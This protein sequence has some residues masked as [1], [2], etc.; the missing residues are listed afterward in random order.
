W[1]ANRDIDDTKLTVPLYDH[2]KNV[3]E[4]IYD[5]AGTFFHRELRENGVFTDLGRQLRTNE[6]EVNNCGPHDGKRLK[7]PMEIDAAP[8]E[9]VEMYL[10]GTPLY[11]FM[12]TPVPLK[13]DRTRFNEHGFVFARSGW[14]KTQALRTIIAQFLEEP[15]PPGLFLIDSLGG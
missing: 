8:Y 10:K 5:L 4:A 12:C 1:E 14:G 3:G 2:L 7:D 6:L 9:L 13:I 11:K 15:D